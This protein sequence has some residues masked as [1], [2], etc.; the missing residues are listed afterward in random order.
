MSRLRTIRTAL[1]FA[2]LLLLPLVLALPYCSARLSLILHGA[3]F[4]RVVPRQGLDIFR[5]VQRDGFHIQA[6]VFSGDKA[7]GLIVQPLGSPPYFESLSQANSVEWSFP[8]G[9]IA[10]VVTARFWGWLLLPAQ[11]IVLLLWLRH[12]EKKGTVLWL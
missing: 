3:P 6:V 5:Y 8:S 10:F 9:F 12:R 1:L 11:G 2:P 7:V 4:A